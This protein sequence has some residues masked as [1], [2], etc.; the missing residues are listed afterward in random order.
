MPRRGAH[1]GGKVLRCGDGETLGFLMPGALKAALTCG[2][3][4]EVLK[5]DI[6]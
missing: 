3:T 1:D 4:T 6:N 2:G 5:A